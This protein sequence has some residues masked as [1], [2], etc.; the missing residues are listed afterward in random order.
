[1]VMSKIKTNFNKRCLLYNLRTAAPRLYNFSVKKPS[2]K[3]RCI[4]A[5]I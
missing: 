4:W 5:N 1:M 3:G 2:N